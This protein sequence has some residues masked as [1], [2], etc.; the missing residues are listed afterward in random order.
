M[1]ISQVTDA[2]GDGILFPD[3][4]VIVRRRG[5]YLWVRVFNAYDERNE[6]GFDCYPLI[7]EVEGATGALDVPAECGVEDPFGILTSLLGPVSEG[8]A[9]AS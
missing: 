4:D 2:E 5:E 7:T 3:A 9:V 8:E 1:R 6:A